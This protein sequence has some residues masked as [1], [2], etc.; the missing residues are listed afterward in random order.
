MDKQTAFFTHL[1]IFTRQVLIG[2]QR[3]SCLRGRS[4]LI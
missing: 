4:S 1:L 3:G 2:L